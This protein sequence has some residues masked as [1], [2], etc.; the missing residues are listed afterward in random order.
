MNVSTHN[1]IPPNVPPARS[2]N[3]GYDNYDIK[4]YFLG[5]TLNKQN[6]SLDSFSYTNKEKL[7]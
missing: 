7:L 3:E 2:G 6:Y 4:L 5:A 1:V